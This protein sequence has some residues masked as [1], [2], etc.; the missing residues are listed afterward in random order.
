MNTHEEFLK[1]K[2]KFRIEFATYKEHYFIYKKK[3]TKCTRYFIQ[4]YNELKDVKDVHMIIDKRTQGI[5]IV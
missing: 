1:D 3:K 5:N 4:H 2:S